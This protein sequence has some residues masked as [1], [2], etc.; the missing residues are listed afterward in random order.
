MR[1]TQ[2][3]LTFA[4]GVLQGDTLTPYIFIICQDYILQMSKDLI[5]VNGFTHIKK[6]GSRRYLAET[7]TGA[8]YADDLALL[9]NTPAKAK[10]QQ[11]SLQ[12][13][14]GGIGLCVTANRNSCLLNKK[15]PSPLKVA[16][17]WNLKTSLHTLAVISRLLKMMSTNALQR[18]GMLSII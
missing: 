17:R 5:K 13:A 7:I 6:A 15:E 12:P 2:T 10:S 18:G 4:I 8:Y 1:V 9:I 11:H 14:A 16:S 3:P